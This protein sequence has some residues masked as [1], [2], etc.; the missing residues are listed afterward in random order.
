M[1]GLLDEL[2]ALATR[3]AADAS[4][5]LVAG[6]GRVRSEVSTKS[7]ATDMV[8]EMDRA[9]EALIVAGL[10]SARPDDGLVGE[11][12]TDER[13]TSGV[14]WLIDPI[15]GTTNYLYGLPGFAVSIAAEV[16]GAMAIGVV[17]SPLH[18]DVFA[19]ARGRGATRNGEAITVSAK[20]DLAT[21]LVATGFSYEAE[22]RRR[23]AAVLAEVLP[24]IRDVRRFGA[25]S[26]DLCSVACRRVDAYYERGLGPWDL[27][28]GGLIA[29]EAGATVGDLAGGPPSGDFVLAAAPAIFHPL[30]ELLVSAGA[31]TA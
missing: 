16:D 22:R 3:L 30:R 14:R 17:D 27:A 5:L 12:G 7:S 28:A 2:L 31:A 18:H 24:R 21:A 19:A 1:D 10:R 13:G 26:V 15:D 4:A 8:T 29:A 23:Q 6:L 11:E 25:A 20:A 9:S